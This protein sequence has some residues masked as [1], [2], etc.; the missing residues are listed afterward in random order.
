MASKLCEGKR[1]LLLLMGAILIL[2]HSTTVHGASAGNFSLALPN[3]PEKCGNMSIPYPFGIGKDSLGKDCFLKK[4]FEVIC[5]TSQQAPTIYIYTGGGSVPYSKVLNFSLL[6]GEARIQNRIHWSCK[7][8][9]SSNITNDEFPAL[10][11][12]LGNSLKVSYTKNKFTA[13]GCATLANIRGSTDEII[14]F[15]FNNL[16]YTSVCSSF[17]DSEKQDGVPLVLDWSVGSETCEEAK[18]NSSSFACRTLN[19]VC[20]N[21]TN[22]SGY[23]CICS[24]G[25]QG[26]PYLDEGCQD[27]NECDDPSIYP[28]INGN[29]IN[30]IGSYNCSCP[31]GTESK[32]P[33]N[34]ACTPVSD[35]N[36][37]ILVVI[38]G[39]GVG[40]AAGFMI[41]V[42][43]AFFITQRFKH[44]RAMKLKQK[45][46]EQNRGQLL[47]QLVSQRTDIAERMIITVDELAKATNN[48][49]PARELG[50]GGHGTSFTKAASPTKVMSTDFGVIV[51]ELSTRKKPFSYFSSNGEGL[52]AHFSK[53]HGE[54]NLIEIL[55]PQ[56]IDE[57]GQEVQAVAAL[58]SSCIRLRSEERPTMRQVNRALEGL[59]SPE[60]HAGANNMLAEE[61]DENGQMMI[62]YPSPDEGQS[63]GESTRWYSLEQESL[64]V[65]HS[66]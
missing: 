5:N 20:I 55:D 22:G 28:C 21:A 47:Q 15:D 16:R 46:F 38:I 29:C 54:G 14:D 2:P 49:D 37:S 4:D 23:R 27:I 34:I 48:F 64:M 39:I 35:T 25:Y 6:D 53:L 50:G 7:Y 57:G 10:S 59:L 3:C 33:K 31:G 66:R 63:M 1:L 45:Y 52:V 24:Q 43:I 42:V 13:I 17:C 18:K 62:G 26:N 8:P 9:N 41:L 60:N 40:S 61:F 36:K 58:A 12:N 65:V 19:S 32:D 11:L 51:V 56:V 44:R 30:T